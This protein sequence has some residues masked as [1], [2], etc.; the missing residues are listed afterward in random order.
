VYFYVRYPNGDGFLAY[1]GAPIG[2][3]GPVS[4][5][6][7]EQA[8]DGVE[9]YQYLALL[10]GLVRET[11]DAAGAALLDR[12]SEL[13]DIP[14]AGGRHST[15]ILPEPEAIPRLRAALA[16]AIERLSGGR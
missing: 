12:A 1:P 5:V 2:H 3:A 10:A 6:R 9:D 14:N 16:E 7:L 4:T 15:R 13:V 11:G 8:R